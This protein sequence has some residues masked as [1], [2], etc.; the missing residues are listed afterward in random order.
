MASV[1]DKDISARVN[2]YIM[3][4]DSYDHSVSKKFGH[5]NRINK[6]CQL[7]SELQCSLDACLCKS[8]KFDESIA[9]GKNGFN[10]DE[11]AKILLNSACQD[12]KHKGGLYSFTKSFV[13]TKLS[14]KH[15]LSPIFF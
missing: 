13:F 11:W 12:C 6:F 9:K 10:D 8:F 5:L 7:L 4:E 14:N 1:V 3:S 2:T 15:K